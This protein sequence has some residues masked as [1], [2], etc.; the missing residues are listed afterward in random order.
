MRMTR[1]RF[2]ITLLALSSA[3][4]TLL[5]LLVFYQLYAVKIVSIKEI[6]INPTSFDGAHVR[7]QGYVVKNS[8]YM[9]G[10]RYVLRDFDNGVEIALGG[11]G[12]S[13]NQVD[14]ESY[15][16]FLFDGRNYTQIRD[17]TV[18]VVGHVRYAGPIMD[19]PPFSLE[20]EKVLDQ[21]KSQS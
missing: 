11:K 21:K 9:F 8:G 20:V 13:G 5:L 3:L 2:F 6:N 12:G 4:A 14:L 16:S 19:A 1:R 7:L 17:L 10:P 18:S 15:V